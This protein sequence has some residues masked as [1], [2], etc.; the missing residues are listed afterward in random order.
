MK[1][2][3]IAAQGIARTFQNLA[4]SLR[5][6]H[7]GSDHDDALKHPFTGPILGIQSKRAD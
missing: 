2:D 3:R 6:H 5:K 1:P 4:L 7:G